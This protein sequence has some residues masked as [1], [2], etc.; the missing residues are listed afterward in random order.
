[1]L[2]PVETRVKLGTWDDQPVIF[3]ISKDISRLML[4]EEKFSKLFY[5]NP[6]ACGLSEVGSGNYVEVNQAFEELLGFSP[7]EVI[8]HSA[9]DL[10]ILTRDAA[11]AKAIMPA[12]EK[13]ILDLE[14]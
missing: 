12:V 1:M 2:V 8:G 9:Y 3:G 13:T 6:S 5:L 14:L 11:H 10:N 4:S 7:E